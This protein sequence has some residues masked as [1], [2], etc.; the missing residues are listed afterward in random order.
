[1]FQVEQ[2]CEAFVWNAEAKPVQFALYY[3]SL[4]PDCQRFFKQ[5]LW[6]TFQKI[7]SIMNLTLVPYG[8][9][10]VCLNYLQ[11]HS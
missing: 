5:Q 10:M 2:Q 4:C 1:L 8:N 6:P 3:E 9:A 11:L 7:S